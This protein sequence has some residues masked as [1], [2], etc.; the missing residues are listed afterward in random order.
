M[1]ASLQLCFAV[2]LLP[3]FGRSSGVPE[4]LLA[5]SEETDPIAEGRERVYEARNGAI[6]GDDVVRFRARIYRWRVDGFR[7][8]D[9]T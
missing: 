8:D 5:Y 3:S 2:S 6:A 1:R 9:G 7:H 4:H